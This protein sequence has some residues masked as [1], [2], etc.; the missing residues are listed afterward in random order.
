VL[1]ID[2]D[3]QGNLTDHLGI[4]PAEGATSSYDVLTEGASVAK[5][6]LATKTP[7]LFVVPAHEDLAAA[8]TEMAAEI[9][10]EVRLKKALDALP[11]DAYDWVLI[12]CPPS[13]GILSLNA[14]AAARE[15]FITLQTEY[16]AMRG[17][18]A[19]DRIV[20]MVRA[21]V[22]PD[23]RISGILATLVNPVTNL[24]KEVLEEVKGHYRERMFKAHIRQN[25]RLAEAPGHRVHVFDY[26]PLS[27]G[28]EDYRALAEEVEAMGKPKSAP[29]HAPK[30]KA[31]PPAKS[32]PKPAPARE[33]PKEPAKAEAPPKPSPTAKPDAK[34][35]VETAAGKPPPPAA[36]PAAPAAPKPAAA[37]PAPR[38]PPPAP[39]PAAAP[40]PVPVERPPASPKNGHPGPKPSAPPPSANVAKSPSAPSRPAP[41]PPPARRV[42]P[43]ATSRPTPP[44]APPT[45]PA[46]GPEASS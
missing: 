17:L 44:P 19:L 7:G 5:A 30:A 35:K 28:A 21:H 3:P 33:T 12:D 23:L 6:A 42:P 16:F 37:A 2:M 25:V 4:D 8:E 15:V 9:G 46:P 40:A 36:S 26:A 11:R 13:L 32:A 45:P 34:P 29:A 43:R 22:N 41:P 14:M 20:E 31:P 38:P 18:G 39:K 1:L 24:A 10:R 27:P